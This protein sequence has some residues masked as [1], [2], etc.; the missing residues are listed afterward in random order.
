MKQFGRHRERLALTFQGEGLVEAPGGLLQLCVLGEGQ[1]WWAWGQQVRVG[2]W[3][4]GTQRRI[5]GISLVLLHREEGATRFGAGHL[6]SP[7]VTCGATAGGRGSCGLLG[8]VAIVEQL[9]VRCDWLPVAG[10]GLLSLQLLLFPPHVIQ[11]DL[12][13]PRSSCSSSSSPVPSSLQDS[14]IH[15][16]PSI[17]QC[18]GAPEH[19]SGFCPSGPWLTIYPQPPLLHPPILLWGLDALQES[20]RAVTVTSCDDSTFYSCSWIRGAGGGG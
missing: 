8:G 20:I 1:L 18:F 7:L 16:R 3:L 15:L 9:V 11:Q 10:L 13:V 6:D 5:V 19:S 4:D 14:I 12:A 2:V 17:H